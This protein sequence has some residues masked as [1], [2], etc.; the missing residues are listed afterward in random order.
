MFGKVFLMD[1]RRSFQLKRILIISLMSL[2]LIVL[3]EAEWILATWN[4]SAKT[5]WGALDFLSN[6]L[7][8][9]RY[10]IILAFFLGALYTSSFCADDNSHYLRMILSRTDITTYTQSRFLANFVTI[11]SVSIIVFYVFVFIL[12]LKFPLVPQIDPING[13]KN[14]YY[15]VIFYQVPFLYVLM[16]AVQF[17]MFVAA[18]SSI[19]LL[20]SAYNSN[21]LVSVGLTGM[22]FYMALS[23]LP[24]NT[25]FRVLELSYLDSPCD[26]F[27][28]FPKGVTYAWGLLYP[29][30][31]IFLSA[32]LFYRRMK[33]RMENG[34]I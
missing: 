21:A 10:K 19:S 33:R 17:G 8:I 24:A 27:N 25:P 3:T 29:T 6:F 16:A 7:R 14:E 5:I 11:L 30:L 32:Y 13:A 34:N 12:L 4:W 18:C 23:Y 26:I 31:V 15:D 20:F 1:C 22:L 2:A 28:F 9:D